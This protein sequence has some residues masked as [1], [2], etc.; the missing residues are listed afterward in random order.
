ML[1]LLPADFRVE[2]LDF[3]PEFSEYSLKIGILLRLLLVFWGH[4]VKFAEEI[5]E[6]EVLALDGVAQ[7]LDFWVFL[8]DLSKQ[9]LIPWIGGVFWRF[10]EVKLVAILW[11]VDLRL[12]ELN[13]R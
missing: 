9:R 6:E 10:S 1:H 11:A 2:I 12:D 13:S 5:F 4:F 8:R 7:I 3:G